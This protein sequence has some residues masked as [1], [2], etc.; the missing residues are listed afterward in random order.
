MTRRSSRLVIGLPVLAGG[1]LIALYGL[2]TFLYRD[3]GGGRTYVT[4]FGRERDAQLV[5]GIA[6]LIGLA[7]ILVSVWFM[8]RRS[9]L[10]VVRLEVPAVSENATPPATRTVRSPP[11]RPS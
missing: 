5:G 6:L 1:V 11:D 2:F 9:S 4:L 10:D 8:R 7:V 3:H